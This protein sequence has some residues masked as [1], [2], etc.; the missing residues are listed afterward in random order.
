MVKR[1]IARL[2][3][4]S[5]SGRRVNVRVGVTLS[6]FLL[7]IGC[8]AQ[9]GVV[10]IGQN[11]YLV[12]KQAATGFPG[13]GNLKAEALQEANQFCIGRGSDLFVTRSTETQP[14]YVLGN[15]PRAEIEFRCASPNKTA[16]AAVAECNA[17]RLHGELKTHKASV[18]C[19]NPKIFAAYR[20]AGDPNLDLLNVY[21]AAQLVGAENIDRK[22]VTEAEYQLQLAELE[23]RLTKERQR[24][25]LDV[26]ELEIKRTQA[27]AEVQTATAAQRQSTAALLVGLAAPQSANRPTSQPYQLPTP[28]ML[29]TNC[30]TY[31]QTTNCQT[32]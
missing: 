4:F 19:S 8:A 17:M 10:P 23:S 18:E 21:L 22:R 28:R 16:E 20:E 5:P 13:L 29:N 24:R 30:Q 25:A 32:Q 9:T 27:A 15:Y 26:A 7:V 12:A 31:G 14:P 3:D 11:S 6:A 2:T 1:P